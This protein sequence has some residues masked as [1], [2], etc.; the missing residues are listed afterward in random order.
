MQPARI[1]SVAAAA[2]GAKD[3]SQNASGS[4]KFVGVGVVVYCSVSVGYVA[5]LACVW[6]CICVSVCVCVCVFVCLGVE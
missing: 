1:P 5:E 3:Y 4:G 2:G 6:M